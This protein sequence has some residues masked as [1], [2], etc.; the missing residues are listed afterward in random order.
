M[1]VFQTGRKRYLQSSTSAYREWAGMSFVLHM[2]LPS[3]SYIS[4]RGN[5]FIITSTIWYSRYLCASTEVWFLNAGFWN[6]QR[7]IFYNA[8]L[9]PFCKECS[10]LHF[11]CVP[12]YLLSITVNAFFSSVHIFAL[13]FVLLCCRSGAEQSR[14]GQRLSWSP[15]FASD[16]PSLALSTCF[17]LSVSAGTRNDKCDRRVRTRWRS[18][19]ED[20][21]D[22]IMPF[23]K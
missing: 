12:L 6:S 3:I 5:F 11:F 13:P 15:I 23:V 8:A 21:G 14:A 16:V 22:V 1:N 10:L 20:G 4:H 2:T 7:F 17:T 19:D 18:S 9:V